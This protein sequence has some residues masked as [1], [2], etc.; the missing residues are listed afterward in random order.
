MWRSTDQGATWTQMA[1]NAEL[2]GS[3][4]FALNVQ[5]DDKILVGGEFTT[6]G[7]H[8][9]HSFARLNADGILDAAFPPES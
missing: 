4:V 2:S 3:T 9:R 8:V 1:N 6:V 5:P 7:G